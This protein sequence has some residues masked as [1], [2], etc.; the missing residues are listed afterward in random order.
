MRKGE[1]VQT[2]ETLSSDSHYLYVLAAAPPPRGPPHRRIQG[3]LATDKLKFIGKTP[4]MSV[5]GTSGIAGL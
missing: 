3:R 2:D 5:P 1:F 4:D